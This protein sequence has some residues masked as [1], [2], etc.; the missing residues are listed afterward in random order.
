MG[1]SEPENTSGAYPFAKTHYKGERSTRSAVC[2][3]SGSRSLRPCRTTLLSILPSAISPRTVGR[4]EVA[5][6]FVG[7]IMTSGGHRISLDLSSNVGTL[8][9][10]ACSSAHLRKPD[11]ADDSGSNVMYA[12]MFSLWSMVWITS[13]PAL[14]NET[15]LQTGTGSDT[16][17][18]SGRD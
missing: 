10:G 9:M 7:E 1:F 8:V 6:H 16:A 13:G 18:P 15:L 2:T 14:A 12:M 4:Q 17:K 5:P 11:K 3:S